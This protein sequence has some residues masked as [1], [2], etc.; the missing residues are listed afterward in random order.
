MT[1]ITRPTD[2]GYSVAVVVPLAARSL[3]FLSGQIGVDATGKIAAGGFEAEVRQCFAN[4]ESALECAG[5]TLEDV[6]RITF[7]LK[8][9][10]DYPTY[11]QVRS[12]IFP[13]DCPASSGIGISDLALGAR[14]EVEA[15]AAIRT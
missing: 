10:A 6:V 15:I 5:S 9:L 4:L 14:V 8:D 12:E 11:A 1:R 2:R 13:V 7:F 3:V